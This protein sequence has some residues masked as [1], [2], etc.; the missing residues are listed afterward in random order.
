ME[1]QLDKNKAPSCRKRKKQDND[2]G[3]KTK[4]YFGYEY[5]V[6]LKVSHPLRPVF[7]QDTTSISPGPGNVERAMPF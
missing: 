2:D 5:S 6:I 7:V 1:N 3:I 4:P